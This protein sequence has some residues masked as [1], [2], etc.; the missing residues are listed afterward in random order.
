MRAISVA[1]ADMPP[2]PKIPATTARSKKAIIQPNIIL[3]LFYKMKNTDV[4]SIADFFL[5]FQGFK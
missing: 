3:F 1:A 4:Y 5:H 2:N